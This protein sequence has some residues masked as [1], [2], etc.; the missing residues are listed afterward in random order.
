[1]KRRKTQL[2]PELSSSMDI[3]IVFRFKSCRLYWISLEIFGI[4]AASNKKKVFQA[5]PEAHAASTVL[6]RQLVSKMA[7]NKKKKD[8]LLK[9]WWIA[10][11]RQSSWKVSIQANSRHSFSIR[12]RFLHFIQANNLNRNICRFHEVNALRMYLC[13]EILKHLL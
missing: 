6:I 8:S 11:S 10:L 2:E 3:F 5:T 1:M 12:P 4:I 13:E 7:N 9:C